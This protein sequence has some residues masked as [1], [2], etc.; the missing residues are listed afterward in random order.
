MMLFEQ[1]KLHENQVIKAKYPGTEKTK[2]KSLEEGFKLLL[3]G[4]KNGS[5]VICGAPAFY[6]PEGLTGIFDVIE[7]RKGAPSIFGS[8]HYIVKEIKLARNM[9]NYHIYQGAFYNYLLGK[10]Q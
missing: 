4:M 3:E 1:G 8:Y 6:L 5:R 7:K 9:Q 10:I 2:Y